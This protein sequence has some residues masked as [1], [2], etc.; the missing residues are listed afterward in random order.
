LLEIVAGTTKKTEVLKNYKSRNLNQ[1][2]TAFVFT[3][4]KKSHK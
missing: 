3:G 2:V 4:Y 1:D